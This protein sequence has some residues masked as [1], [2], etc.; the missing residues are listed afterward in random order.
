M[1]RWLV[2]AVVA[3]VVLAIGVFAAVSAKDSDDS[4]DKSD[5]TSQSRKHQDDRGGRVKA[6]NEGQGHGPPSWAHSDKGK[7]DKAAR[8]EWREEWRQ[9]T[10]AQ[11]REVLDRLIREHVE[12]M[13]QW[14]EC[15]LAER[16]DCEMPYPP[17][18]AKRR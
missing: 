9:L 17:G 18:L 12:G 14:R 15:V 16:D 2:P 5:K 11:R 8:D 10:P 4:D 1:K 7:G 6:D 13:E 3:A